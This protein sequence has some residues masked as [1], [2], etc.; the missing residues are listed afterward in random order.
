MFASNAKMTPISP[1]FAAH[2]H[3]RMMTTVMGKRCRSLLMAMF[4][5]HTAIA[6]A[7]TATCKMFSNI[8]VHCLQLIQASK[9]DVA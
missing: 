5:L 2:G 3:S 8:W 1:E 4:P 6:M 9:V 7:T